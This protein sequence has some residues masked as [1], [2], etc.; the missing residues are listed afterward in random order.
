[1]ASMTMTVAEREKKLKVRRID[2]VIGNLC[3]GISYSPYSLALTGELR[4]WPC[5]KG[6]TVQIQ[7]LCFTAYICWALE[8]EK[9]YRT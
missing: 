5:I 8:P 2:K 4:Y 1:M 6:Y 3:T 7:I 9:A